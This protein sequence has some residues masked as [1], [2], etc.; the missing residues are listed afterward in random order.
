MSEDA[1]ESYLWLE[2]ERHK[3]YHNMDPLDLL[4][5]KLGGE[6]NYIAGEIVITEAD[7]IS[8]HGLGVCWD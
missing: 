1:H 3:A 8:M 4:R 6:S 2:Y 5:G 7:R